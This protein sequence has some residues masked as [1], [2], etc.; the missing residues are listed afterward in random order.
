MSTSLS[1]GRR[2]RPLVAAPP[3]CRLG[4]GTAVVAQMRLLM[5]PVAHLAGA[6]PEGGDRA[7][8]LP[9]DLVRPLRPEYQGSLVR[10][11]DTP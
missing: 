9:A 11:V 3:P 10:D 1:L 8:L 2:P 4:P 7:A 5:R 6:R